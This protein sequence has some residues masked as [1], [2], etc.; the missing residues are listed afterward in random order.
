[1]GFDAQ[2]GLR[3][4]AAGGQYSGRRAGTTFVR[5]ARQRGRRGRLLAMLLS[6]AALALA[7]GCA[8]LDQ[9]F[10]GEAELQPANADGCAAWFKKLDYA[11]DRADVRDAEAAQIAGFPYLRIN[12]F[13]A[14]FRDQAKRDA[15]A[16]TAWEKRLRA[17]DAQARGY[18]LKNLPPPALVTLDAGGR[19]DALARTEQCAAALV[20]VDAT[21]AARRDALIRR[22]QVADDYAE[23]KRT[24]GV[25]PAVKV[26]FF[27]FAKKWQSEATAMFEQTAAATVDHANL[28]RYQPPASD[29]SAQRIATLIAKAKTDALGIPEL[30]GSDGDLLFAAFAPVIEIETTGDYDR[31]GPLRWGVGETPEVDI[32][33]PTAYRRL[34]FTRYGGRTLPQLV[35]MIWFPERPQSSAFDPLSGKLDGIVFRATLDATGRPLIYDSIHLCG[36]YHM[37]FPTPRMRPKPPPDPD[38]EWAFVPRILPA[39]DLPQ[40]VV[41]RLTSRSHYL[42]D[43]RPEVG[44]GGVTYT[45]MDDGQLRTLPTAE[46][47]RSAFGPTG[48]VTGTE[49]GERLVTW[50]LG[51]E[52]AGAMREWGRHATALI[53]RRQFDDADLIERRFELIT[54]GSGTGPQTSVEQE[55]PTRSAANDR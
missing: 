27:A 6:F 25:Y 14:S 49:R 31:F 45:M 12:R 34:A 19:A 39:M 51:I 38:I 15:A 42:I 26:P 32:A 9:A 43:V 13:L 5:L 40:R 46:G 53:G 55:L 23:W 35:Y 54:P 17:L 37:F 22:A 4:A 3:F 47:T 1:M 48:I 24:V 7:S 33:R 2:R 28:V 50:P 41:I 30:S 52:S 44:G 20:R 11:T 10:D 18:E 29:A 16:F 8:D 36:C 21:D